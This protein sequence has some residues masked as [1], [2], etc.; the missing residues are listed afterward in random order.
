MN[1]VKISPDGK[2]MAA[3]SDTGELII[4]SVFDNK[5][6]GKHPGHSQG[7]SKVGWTLD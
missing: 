5:I 3:G 7:I 4:I 1:A 6:L 2:Y